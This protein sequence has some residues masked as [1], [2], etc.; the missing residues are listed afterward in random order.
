MLRKSRVVYDR[1][2]QLHSVP[3]HS[4]STVLPVRTYVPEPVHYSTAVDRTAVLYS[5]MVVG[6]GTGTVQ[7]YC[8]HIPRTGIAYRYVNA[9]AGQSRCYVNFLAKLS[10]LVYVSC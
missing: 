6:T 1:T 2:V 7:L 3:A 5:C 4:T 10:M 8:V 9:E